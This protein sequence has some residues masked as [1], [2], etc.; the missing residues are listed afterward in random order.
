MRS[1]T[2][3]WAFVLAVATLGASLGPSPANADFSAFLR[4]PGLQGESRD[5]RH[6]NEIDLVS[7]T[8]AVGTKACLK[9][10]AVKNLDRA[11]PGLAALALTGTPVSSVKVTLRKNGE[12]PV[13][14]FVAVLD[15]MTIGS[16]ELMEVDGAP[17]LTERVVLLPRRAT[18][19]Y[20]PQMEDGSLG[21]SITT[22]VTCP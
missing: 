13:D 21:P 15:N 7:Y 10:I 19:T 11:S 18:L 5:S 2:M 6:M 1:K 8:Q 3:L 22:T 17:I 12:N 14:V 9:V 16:V 20:T 4:I